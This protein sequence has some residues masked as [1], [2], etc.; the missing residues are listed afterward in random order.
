MV[1]DGSSLLQCGDAVALDRI[2]VIGP[3]EMTG[4]TQQEAM[5]RDAQMG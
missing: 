3:L 2:R 5:H 4:C 1:G